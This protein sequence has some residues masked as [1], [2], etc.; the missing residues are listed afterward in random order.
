MMLTD[1]IDKRE[2]IKLI[3]IKQKP[4]TIKWV[5]WNVLSSDLTA[6]SSCVKTLG[7]G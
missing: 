3:M 6:L 2:T 4:V 1:Y 7:T 5:V